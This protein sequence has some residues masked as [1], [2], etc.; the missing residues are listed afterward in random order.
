MDSLQPEWC[1]KEE[2]S[3]KMTSIACTL[4]Y[5]PT[6]LYTSSDYHDDDDP[7]R[8]LRIYSVCAGEE[9]HYGRWTAV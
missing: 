5:L 9:R 8:L 3:G 4:N 6:N 2:E 1:E 7:D